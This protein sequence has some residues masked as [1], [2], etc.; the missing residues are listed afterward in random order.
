[1]SLEVSN[2]GAL[3]RRFNHEEKSMTKSLKAAC[4]A[5]ITLAGSAVLPHAVQAAVPV[6][7][8]CS[9]LPTQAQLK[10]ALQAAVAAGNGGFGLNMWGTIVATDGT[11]CAVAYSGTAYTSQWL[12]SRAISAQKANTAN[13]FSLD[14]LALSTANL[15]SATQPGGSLFGLQFS[16]PVDPNVAYPGVATDYGTTSDPMVGRRIGGVNVFGGGL[17]LYANSHKIGAVGVSGDSSCADHNISWR[18][19]QTLHL[20][21]IPGGVGFNGT[22][23]IVYDITNGKSASGWGH[24]TCVGPEQNVAFSIGAGGPKAPA[25]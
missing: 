10:S 7:A 22:D 16:N 17:A 1:L 9:G 6:P 25:S 5:A 2:S 19:R 18:V 14:N 12:G 13:D 4:A 20:D 15:Y 11:V 21:Q 23:G 3:R 24:P 8:V